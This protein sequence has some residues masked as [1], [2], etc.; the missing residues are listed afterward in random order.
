VTPRVGAARHPARR[1]HAYTP[2]TEIRGSARCE[3]CESDAC[4]KE[5]VEDRHGKR[6][7]GTGSG[8]EAGCGGEKKG[9]DR[10]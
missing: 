1:S 5:S 10:G 7:T 2:S 3:S 8:A 6:A 9:I 4:R